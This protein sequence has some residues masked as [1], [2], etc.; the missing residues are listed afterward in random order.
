MKKVGKARPLAPAL[1]QLFREPLTRRARGT[2]NRNDLFGSTSEADRLVIP[3]SLFGFWARRQALRKAST[4]FNAVIICTS[5][6]LVRI[7]PSLLCPN[8]IR[9]WEGILSL[10]HQPC[11]R[12]R[13]V[14]RMLY[15]RVGCNSAGRWICGDLFGIRRHVSGAVECSTCKSERP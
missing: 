12:K 1:K 11:R 15:S 14:H 2:Y 8:C 4:C 7:T 13:Q 10:H 5:A 3:A 9:N 6:C